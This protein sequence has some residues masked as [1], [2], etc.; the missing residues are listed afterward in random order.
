M[1]AE[2]VRLLWRE[3][4]PA[5]FAVPDELSFDPELEDTSWHNDACPS[6]TLT[7]LMVAYL[8]EGRVDLRLWVDHPE[9]DRRE[10]EQCNRYGVYDHRNLCGHYEGDDLAEAVRVLKLVGNNAHFS[11]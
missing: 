10:F 11:V 5:D 2:T 9:Q 8:A 3:E 6:F 4:F 1:S 7:K